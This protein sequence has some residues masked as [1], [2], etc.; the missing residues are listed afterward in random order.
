[1]FYNFKKSSGLHKLYD[2][3]SVEHEEDQCYSGCIEPLQPGVIRCGS[4]GPLSV[5]DIEILNEM[6]GCSKECLGYRY[7]NTKSE[8]KNPVVV[9]PDPN[10]E[11]MYTCRAYHEGDIIPGKYNS[12]NGECHVPWRGGEHRKT[13]EHVEVLTNPSRE[14]LV[15][16]ESEEIPSTAIRGG[17]TNERET[18][19]VVR[20][21]AK[22]N[23]ESVWFPGKYQVSSGAYLSFGGVELRCGHFEYLVCDQ[24]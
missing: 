18:L 12:V 19:Y 17:R 22:V 16:Q 4:G 5:L 1:M 6:Y 3:V 14:N 21:E 7:V 13:G 11:I 24:P 2:Y 23:G 8:F 15:W 20:C 9:G 10:G